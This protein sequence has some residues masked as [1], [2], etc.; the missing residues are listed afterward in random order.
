M[1]TQAPTFG[2]E[3]R[4]R[5]NESG[6]SLTDMERLVHATRSHLSKI[7]RGHRNPSVELARACDAK[8]CADGRLLAL[9]PAAARTREERPASR[10][11]DDVPW[12]LSVSATGESTFTACD[13]KALADGHSSAVLAHWALAPGGRE[14]VSVEAA[15]PVFH[16]VFDEYRRLGQCSGP[17]LVIPLSSTATGA[18]RGLAHSAPPACSAAVLRLAARF[19]EYTGWMWQEAG[20][21]RA[22]RWWTEQ[23]ARLAAS[24]GDHEMTAY[25]LLRRAELALYQG[26]AQTTVDLAEAAGRQARGLRTR[27]L[28][29]QREAQGYALMGSETQCRRAL[30]RGAELVESARTRTDD[31][32]AL[33]STH[34]PDLAAFVAAWCLRELGESEAAVALLDAGQDTIAPHAL[35]ARA[36]HGARLAL[37]LAD[38]DEIDRACAV[39]RSVAEDVRTTDSATVRADL[40]QLRSSLATRRKHPAVRDI[41]PVITA[42]L[43]GA[44]TT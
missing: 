11:D 18:L 4:R 10:G 23:A 43:R 15:L 32:P 9:L 33:G 3:L 37:A 14:A 30:D 27:E 13:P 24:C 2:E 1:S 6:K 8:L 34:L 20:D 38:A 16:A 39:A 29:A 12:S 28:A 7:E 19:A 40:R 41:L 21:D 42:S 31:A 22:A 17:A 26:D 5:R 44:R 35:R 25:T 36:R